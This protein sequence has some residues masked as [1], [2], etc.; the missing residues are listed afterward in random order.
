MSLINQMLQDLE[1]RQPDG[2]AE[3]MPSGVTPATTVQPASRWRWIAAGG[4][5]TV[6]AVLGLRQLPDKGADTA[7]MPVVAA[8]TAN[9]PVAPA[10]IPT[11]AVVEPP[12]SE[13][14]PVA[15]AEP[16]P[17]ASSAAQ[18]AEKKESRK[19]RRKRE[20][21]ER[22]E[23]KKALA[24]ETAR[25]GEG[26]KPVAGQS[27]APADGRIV[28]ADRAAGAEQAEVIYQQA[29]DAFGQ[30][31]IGDSVDKA[32][33]VL[34]LDPGHT[35]A[36]QLLAK[37]LLEQRRLEEARTVLR[38]GAQRQPAQLQ[39]STLLTRLELERGDV[40]AA[41]QAVD[42][43][44]PHGAG[45]PDFLALA[46]AVAQ[47]QSKPGE[48]A[49]FYR[50]ALQ[51]KPAEGRSWVGLGL[52][53]EADGHRPEAREAFRRALATETLNPDLSELAERKSR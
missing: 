48:A 2:G 44:L 16:A 31:R 26:N 8:S 29:A 18:A 20:R 45:N 19:E 17:K 51:L 47:R 3:M 9:N 10:Q 36:R 11:P 28:R 7:K 42:Q 21:L 43:A 6:L 5:L 38:E 27:R 52:A 22:A 25:A 14:A 32:R 46:G 33:Q 39:W 53:L 23:R 4:A 50:R 41:R 1:K 40:A 49:D 15:V 34:A 37:Q 24:A 35:A 12:K 30:G 13:P